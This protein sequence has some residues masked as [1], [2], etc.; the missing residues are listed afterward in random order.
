MAAWNDPET[1]PTPGA[2]KCLI[3]IAMFVCMMISGSLLG[4]YLGSE[5]RATWQLIGGLI[6]VIPAYI[7][8]TDLYQTKGGDNR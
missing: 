6:F 1:Q 5:L 8:W 2:G 4:F 3:F 7:L